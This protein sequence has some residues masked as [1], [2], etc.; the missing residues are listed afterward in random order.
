MI[1]KVSASE[2]RK[3]LIAWTS[4][5]ISKFNDTKAH[6]AVDAATR[7]GLRMNIATNE[8]IKP[9]RFPEDYYESLSPSHAE[10]NFHVPL[11]I[12]DDHVQTLE[13]Q[14]QTEDP[15][16]EVEV[17]DEVAIIEESDDS[18]I[19]E[20]DQMDYATVAT[21][22][23]NQTRQRIPV[24]LKDPVKED[25]LIPK[26]S[27]VE[28]KFENLGWYRGTVFRK[29]RSTNLWCINFDN[30]NQQDV[31][32]DVLFWRWASSDEIHEASLRT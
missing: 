11:S 14:Q 25:Q 29:I 15:R 18:A 12:F 3:L 28:I 32:F 19:E 13:E 24:N 1:G 22:L 23:T 4:K 7:T 2:K 6:L 5:A 26:K 30:T 16:Q 17:E 27:R 20:L 21:V 9:V 31:V 10:Y 8:G